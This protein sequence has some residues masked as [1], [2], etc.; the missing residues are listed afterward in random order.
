MRVV[1][2]YIVCYIYKWRIHYIGYKA[3]EGLSLIGVHTESTN[4]YECQFLAYAIIYVNAKHMCIEQIRE[5]KSYETAAVRPPTP[6][7]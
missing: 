3:Y 5:A 7:L 2:V 1:C 6:H 4:P